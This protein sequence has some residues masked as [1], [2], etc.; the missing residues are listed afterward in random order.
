MGGIRLRNCS[1]HVSQCLSEKGR[2]VVVKFGCD[3]TAV[4]ARAANQWYRPA[5][6]VRV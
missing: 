5:K 3:E 4:P 6:V 2:V 1:G